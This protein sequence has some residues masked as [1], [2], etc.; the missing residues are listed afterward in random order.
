MTKLSLNSPEAMAAQEVVAMEAALLA[1]QP[2]KIS[3]VGVEDRPR[4]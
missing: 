3:Y 1:S 2:S 4:S